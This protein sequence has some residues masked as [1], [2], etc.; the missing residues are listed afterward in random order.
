M[1][2]RKSK[3][4][5]NKNRLATLT[6]TYEFFGV[7]HTLFISHTTPQRTATKRYYKK[8]VH[9][10]S[11]EIDVRVCVYLCMCAY[12]EYTFKVISFI[13]QTNLLKK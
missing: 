2:S 11:C 13:K 4:K 9:K 6:H 3:A 8:N 1:K 12:N 10:S 5:R 7:L